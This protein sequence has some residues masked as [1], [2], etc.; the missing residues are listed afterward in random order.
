[1]KQIIIEETLSAS[2]LIRFNKWLKGI[3]ETESDNDELRIGAL[4][5][6]LITVPKNI[7]RFTKTY[8]NQNISNTEWD[9]LM[10]ME[11][12][13]KDFIKANR[14]DLLLED[15]EKQKS[16][17]SKCKFVESDLEIS[18]HMKC[19]YDMFSF[20]ACTGFDLKTTM[21]KTQK[22]FINGLKYMDQ[23]QS[24]FIYTSL[25][26]LQSDVIIGVSKVKPYKVFYVDTVAEGFMKSGREKL[27]TTLLNFYLYA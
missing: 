10:S 1:M 9:L 14:I 20:P 25:S 15:A 26:G 8:L 21:A 24:R 17:I 12:S 11:R 27:L 13:Y 3:A 22:E 19:I 18:C 2:K 5:D 6:S 23:D 16:F 7:N 4:F